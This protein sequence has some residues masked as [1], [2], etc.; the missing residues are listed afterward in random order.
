M[1]FHGLDA[2]LLQNLPFFEQYNFF[3]NKELSQACSTKK[4]LKIF[5]Q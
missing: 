3:K 4:G 5:S 1:R 2:R